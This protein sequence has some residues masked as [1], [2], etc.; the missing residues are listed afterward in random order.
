MQINTPPICLAELLETTI[1]PTLSVEE[2]ELAS[3]VPNHL[4]LVAV[5]PMQSTTTVAPLMNFTCP[6][7]EPY[8]ETL[9]ERYQSVFEIMTNGRGPPVPIRYHSVIMVNNA[10]IVNVNC[11]IAGGEYFL[12]DLPNGDHIETNRSSI[13]TYLNNEYFIWSMPNECGYS[14]MRH[15][16]NFLSVD[17]L[18]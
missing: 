6:V 12:W 17:F 4:P 18:Y 7:V 14:D 15:S 11:S 1:S 10:T 3:L 13:V 9:Q 16:H 8:V 5:P 2:R